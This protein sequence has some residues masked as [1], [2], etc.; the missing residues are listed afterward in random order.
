MSPHLFWKCTPKKFNA[1]CKVHARMHNVGK[2]SKNGNRTPKGGGV[3]KP[4]TY[5]DQIM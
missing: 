1:L 2:S 3:G 4:N 5:I